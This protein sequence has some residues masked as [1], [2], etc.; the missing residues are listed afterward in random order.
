MNYCEMLI[1]AVVQ[2]LTEFLPVS[3]SGHLVLVPK[4]CGFADPGLAVDAFLH[5]GTLFAVVIYFRS[6]IISMIRSFVS[7]DKADRKLAL[8]IVLASVPAV[9]IGF[10]FKSFF[11]SDLIRSVNSIIITLIFGSLLMLLA[12][13]FS[14]KSSRIAELSY[15]QMFFVGVMQVLALFP[16]TSR[17]GATLSAG[18]FCGLTREHAARFAFLVGLPAVAG[19]GLLSLKDL[20]TASVIES[21]WSVLFFGLLVSFVSGYIAI[22]LL[23]KFLAKN[24]PMIFVIYRLL[25]AATLYLFI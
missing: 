6:D 20:A 8:G 2:G 14:V 10:G 9:V 15:K 18:L 12:D 17:S 13:R 1:L 23:I 21:D 25:L 5:L 4:L 22:D 19:A 16:G 7:K 24:S 11:E 3:S